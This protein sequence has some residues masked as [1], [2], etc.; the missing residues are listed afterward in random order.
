MAVSRTLASLGVEGDVAQACEMEEIPVP[1]ADRLAENRNEAVCWHGFET[2][3][4]IATLHHSPSTPTRRTVLRSCLRKRES[5]GEL[6]S[7]V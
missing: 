1:D 4:W 2:L 3:G 7:T 5:E 6:F